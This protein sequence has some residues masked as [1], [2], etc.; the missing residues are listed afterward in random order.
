MTVMRPALILSAALAALIL[1]ACCGPN[2]CPQAKSGA[3]VLETAVGT[4]T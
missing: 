1:Q 2:A 4:R 3:S